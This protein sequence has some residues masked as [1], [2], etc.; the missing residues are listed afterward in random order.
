MSVSGVKRLVLDMRMDMQ[1]HMHLRLIRIRPR[2]AHRLQSLP[3]RAVSGLNMAANRSVA[4]AIDRMRGHCDHCSLVI[5]AWQD[6]GGLTMHELSSS[7][8]GFTPD[9]LLIKPEFGGN[10]EPPA[11]AHTKHPSDSRTPAIGRAQ[12]GYLG[13]PRR[14]KL[15]HGCLLRGRRSPCA[16]PEALP[17]LVGGPPIS[18]SACQTRRPA[19]EP[20]LSSIEE[21]RT[22]AVS[23]VVA[24]GAGGFAVSPTLGSLRARA[25][26]APQFRLAGAARSVLGPLLRPLLVV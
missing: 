2:S 14:P 24:R 19:G 8:C 13:R 1:D 3:W 11:G 5:W 23:Q 6:A 17:Q 18:S 16:L 7:A 25:V 20:V 22:V 21:G 9:Q 12:A 15:A 10:A 4:P 26:P